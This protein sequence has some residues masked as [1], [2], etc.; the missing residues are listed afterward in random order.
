[1][2]LQKYYIKCMIF[3]QDQVILYL[4]DSQA[5]KIVNEI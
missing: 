4:G 5:N 2:I 1:M 3:L